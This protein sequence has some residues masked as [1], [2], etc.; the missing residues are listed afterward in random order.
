MGET[1]DITITPEDVGAISPDY[2][3]NDGTAADYIKNR[4]FYTTDPVDTV[5]MEESTINNWEEWSDASYG[6]EDHSI[7]HDL[8][9]GQSYTVVWDG[10]TYENLVCFND[11]RNSTIGAPYGDYSVYPFGIY[12]TYDSIVGIQISSSKFADGNTSVSHTVSIITQLENVIQLPE[13]YISYKPGLKVEGKT[14]TINNEEV[15][16]GVGAEIFNSDGEI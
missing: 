15:T 4:P 12:D 1:G 7:T 2:N 6:C 11:D 5:I 13:K 14:F 10:T 8:V 9:L 3:Q 16:A